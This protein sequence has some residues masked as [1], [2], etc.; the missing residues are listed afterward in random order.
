MGNILEAT[1]DFPESL[2]A[3]HSSLEISER[4]NDLVGIG[5]AYNNI[6][7]VY[8]EQKT[9]DDFNKAIVYY[10]K[11]KAIFEQLQQK[12]NLCVALFNIGDN[13]E[14]MGNLDSAWRYQKQA[15]Q[16]AVQD[17]DVNFM[18]ITLVNL[19]Y[20]QFKKGQT[21]SAFKNLR[22]GIQY[23]IESD[24]KESLPDAWHSLSECFERI[25][26]IDSSI[27]YA[28]KSLA[29][30]ESGSNKQ[31]QLDAA[32][33]LVSLYGSMNAFDSGFK[34]SKL[35]TE[36]R[37]NIYDNEKAGEIQ[38]MYAREQIRQQ[39]LEAQKVAVAKKRADNLQIIS[40]SV[41]IITF[42]CCTGNP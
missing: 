34:Y 41:F 9:A 6:A 30:A 4:E 8:T 3:H 33:Q 32:N 16:M 14:K 39:E 26:L 1:S 5:A 37:G 35:A 22:S 25:K 29:T 27:Y 31:A 10:R 24:D 36:L 13:F 7:R 28:K 20:I 18:G 2:K 42:F 19:G 15:Y 11:A 40:I 38:R 23:L 21:D 17:E 12:N